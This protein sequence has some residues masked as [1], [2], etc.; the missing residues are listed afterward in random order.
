VS[1]GKAIM[2]NQSALAKLFECD[3]LTISN[4]IKA[5]KTLGMLKLKKKGLKGGSGSTYSYR[6]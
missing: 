1:G 5:L 6:G 3:P 4:R 2:L